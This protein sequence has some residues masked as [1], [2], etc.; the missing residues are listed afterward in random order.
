MSTYWGFNALNGGTVGKLQVKPTSHWQKIDRQYW[1][2]CGVETG[3]GEP[4]AYYFSV[5]HVMVRLQHAL[6]AAG[7]CK[8]G[9]MILAGELHGWGFRRR[10]RGTLKEFYRCPYHEDL[11]ENWGKHSFVLWYVH[12]LYFLYIYS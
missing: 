6:V 9:N 1:Q 12:L 5:K 11:L 4:Y 7:K 8:G 10:D 2:K 3:Y